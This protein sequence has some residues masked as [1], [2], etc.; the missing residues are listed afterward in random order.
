LFVCSFFFLDPRTKTKGEKKT[1]PKRGEK[2]EELS[3]LANW[4][5]IKGKLKKGKE[6]KGATTLSVP[7]SM[8]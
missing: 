1:P 4:E 8:P 6:K 2:G 3:A 5:Q 7:R